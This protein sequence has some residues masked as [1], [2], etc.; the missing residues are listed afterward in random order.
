MTSANV[1]GQTVDEQVK[2]T[3]ICMRCRKPFP[4]KE[5]K[6]GVNIKFSPLPRLEK[7]PY[8]A[9]CYYEISP[10]ARENVGGRF[11]WAAPILVVNL[12]LL[13]LNYQ[14]GFAGFAFWLVIG[15]VFVPGALFMWRAKR[16]LRPEMPYA[17][18]LP[19][20]PPP[21]AQRLSRPL[22]WWKGLLWALVLTTALVLVLAVFELLLVE[23]F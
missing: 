9:T 1:P 8:C 12:S 17:K 3:A 16:V 7:V 6:P 23:L 18:E 22:P 13:A 11:K 15:L 5:M 21:W 10:L 4:L 2:R 20:L 14:R 19:P